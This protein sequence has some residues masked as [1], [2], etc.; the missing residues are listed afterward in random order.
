MDKTEL[1]SQ[2]EL[3]EWSGFKQR[4]GLIQWLLDNR[5]PF[6]Y[7]KGGTIVTTVSAIN[8]PLIGQESIKKKPKLRK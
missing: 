6:F 2:P 4:T 1:L 7:G 5:I 3:M 8:S